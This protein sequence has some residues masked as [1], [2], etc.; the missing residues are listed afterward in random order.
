M[1]QRE[2]KTDE[3]DGHTGKEEEPKRG[4]K[5]KKKQWTKHVVSF[6]LALVMIFTLIPAVHAA[7]NGEIV[8]KAQGAGDTEVDP[9]KRTF[10]AYK[11]L[12]FKPGATANTGAYTVPDALF[13]AY[14]EFLTTNLQLNDVPQEKGATFDNY[15]Q[16]KLSDGTVF[17]EQARREFVAFML[18][19]AKAANIP[20][21]DFVPDTA[22]KQAKATGLDLGYYIIEDTTDSLAEKESRALISLT[23][24][25]TKA[26]LNVKADKNTGEKKI[27]E[28][29]QLVD[30]NTAAIGDV[31]DYVYTTKVSPNLANYKRY[32]FAF[33]DKLCKGLTLQDANSDGFIIKIGTVTLT[34]ATTDALA[35]G[36][37]FVTKTTNQDETTSVSIVFKD[38]KT[39]AGVQAG[40][41][42]TIEYSAKVNEKADPANTGNPNE[43]R[44]KYSNDPNKDD[45]G[46]PEGETPWDKVITYL[47][48]IE[49]EKVDKQGNH[50]AGA[51]FK[52]TGNGLNLSVVTYQTF[53]KA[54]DGT[55]WK[56]KNGTYTTQDPNGAGIDPTV[57][58]STTDKYKPVTKTEV[59]GAGQ[60]AVDVKATTGADGKIKFTGLKPGDYK[61]EEITAP[62]GYN[63]LNAPIEFTIGV[64]L[65]HTDGNNTDDPVW[66]YTTKPAEEAN[67]FDKNTINL[68]KIEN[69]Q[70]SE[71]PG[72]GGI[73]TTVLYTVAS[74]TA[75]AAA[76]FI[77][78]KKRAEQK[79]R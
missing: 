48:E 47:T 42:I 56:M 21:V 65:P 13:D 73:G 36:D 49:I 25:N 40:A 2:Q 55:Y 9:S 35:D 34:R 50:L 38:L 66:T 60:T 52:L 75:L 7:G 69:N 44:V 1:E 19:K 43:A 23:T 5:M 31:V 8:I 28:N 17:T 32:S 72:L 61:L 76:I 15:V 59:M 14:K 45:K 20:A 30:Q 78:S 16:T 33:E 67:K 74:V 79:N 12:D 11:I 70:G 51:E 77:V 18:P 29:G 39:I 46:T 6:V 62:Y 58:E 22:N 63:M 64:T 10:Q 26:E 71:I 3:S 41:N 54:A 57:Y 4:K 24:T 37:Y 27:K 68:L 53:E